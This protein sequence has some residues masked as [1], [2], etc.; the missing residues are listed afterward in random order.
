LNEGFATYSDALYKQYKYG[1][2][3]FKTRMQK[4][5][6]Y[7]FSEDSTIRYAIYDPPPDYLFRAVVY[8][9]GAW[10]LHMLRS[11]V[12]D[13]LFFDL[14]RTYGQKYKFGNAVTTEFAAVAESVTARNLDWFF[15]EWVFEPGHPEYVYWW[16]SDSLGPSN[17]RVNLSIDQ[18][19]SNAPIFNMPIDIG[20]LFEA[21]GS[22][23]TVVDSTVLQEFDIYV[24]EKPFGLDFD[25]F[26]RILKLA[27]E[28]VPLVHEAGQ[29]SAAAPLRYF[30]NPSCGGRPVHLDFTPG[31]LTVD[32]GTRLVINDIAGR[33]VRTFAVTDVGSG[34]HL[35]WDLRDQSGLPVRSGTYFLSV[36]PSG[37]GPSGKLVL[38][39]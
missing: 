5:A 23:F 7:Y 15:D 25:P 17:Y 20:V 6:G 36:L 8:E 24:A 2:A 22:L 3:E 18:V 16:T 37:G 30:P 9:K 39:R 38:V 14:L 19:Q 33:V 13:S 35:D 32:A 31:S 12:G 34:L 1:E 21:G 27:R 11:I 4:F 28:T 29:L 10:V 26:E